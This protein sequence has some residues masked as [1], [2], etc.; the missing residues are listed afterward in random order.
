MKL[1]LI[2]PFKT[3][4]NIYS[5]K[6]M[7]DNNAYT[8]FWE[9]VQNYYQNDDCF[10]ICIPLNNEMIYESIDYDGNYLSPEVF[11]LQYDQKMIDIMLLAEKHFDPENKNYYS[12]TFDYQL[13]KTV[14]HL[15]DNSIGILETEIFIDVPYDQNEQE[16]DW[17]HFFEFIQDFSNKY[18][19]F[20]ISHYYKKSIKQ[21][22]ESCYKL[23]RNY[24]FLQKNYTDIQLMNRNE[25]KI[26]NINKYLLDADEFGKPLWVNRTLVINSIQS[27]DI[28]LNNWLSLGE[29]SKEDI[30][31]VL[32]EDKMYFG[33]GNNIAVDGSD[34]KVYD[35]AIE[36]L[37]LCQY[38]NVA[39][40]NLNQKFSTLTGSIYQVDKKKRIS[41]HIEK[42][43]YI[44]M[45]NAEI[46]FMQLKEQTINLQGHRKKYFEE[47]TN[48]WKLDVIR[49]SIK[50]KRMISENKIQQLDKRRSKFNHTISETILFG[51]GGL[52]LVNLTLD[53]SEY[54]RN[55][56]AKPEMGVT[57]KSVGLVSVGRF[58][59]PDNMAWI[60]IV[61]LVV[62]LSVFVVVKKR[63]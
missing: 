51:I 3:N 26:G 34:D 8:K 44:N 41:N 47:L 33:W 10:N 46:L 13:N 25:K 31:K 50:E 7:Q 43:L 16:K 27:H 53:V 40:D 19:D 15:Y 24:S 56:I 60:G 63:S 42:L 4:F 6:V 20:L 59:S 1:K 29:E 21:Y 5:F 14:C 36:A 32:R 39:L 54:A 22:I 28:F 45:E 18:M 23:D 17:K 2:A 38:Y 61:F 37:N 57:D 62:L 11:K 52:A 35:F 30:L 48:K 12:I 49:D 9:T 55:I 58:V